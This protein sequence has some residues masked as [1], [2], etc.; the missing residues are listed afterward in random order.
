MADANPWRYATK[1]YDTETG[2]Y[3]FGHR[4]YDPVTGQWLNREPLG[5]DE[6]LN[7]TSYCHNDPVNAVDVLGLAEHRF[8][9]YDRA[10]YLAMFGAD[11]GGLLYDAFE[12]RSDLYSNLGLPGSVSHEVGVNSIARNFLTGFSDQSEAG[13]VAR[14]GI[15]WFESTKLSNQY[16]NL[17]GPMIGATTWRLDAHEG[18]LSVGAGGLTRRSTGIVGSVFAIPVFRNHVDINPIYWVAADTV[19]E[20]HAAIQLAARTVEMGR[21][22]GFVT[23]IAEVAPFGAVNRFSRL[24]NKFIAMADRT[25]W[26]QMGSP[27]RRAANTGMVNPAELRWSQTTAGGNG[28]ATLYRESL[29]REGWKQGEFIDVVRT[30]DGLATLDHT[31]AAVALEL[32]MRG[33]PARFH[34]P[35]DALPADLLTRPW[36]R[37]GD[38]ARTWGEA[39]MLRGAGQTPPIGPTGTPIPPRLPR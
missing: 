7:L 31:R 13:N 16:Q 24:G 1:Y 38:T 2:L 26:R 25:A 20:H 17:L 12:R 39:L 34:D 21:V 10:T 15:L 5:E 27:Y 18:E 14:E 11:A 35:S 30:P 4:Y 19:E 8:T 3:Y 37:A 6:S 32:Q 36:N 22:A 23:Q 28:R 29:A 9:I 33:I